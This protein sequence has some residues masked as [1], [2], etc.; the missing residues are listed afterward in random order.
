VAAD[1]KRW[2]AATLGALALL[3]PPSHAQTQRRS[4]I[5]F[6]SPALQALQRDDAQNPAQLWVKD[7]EALWAQAAPGGPACASCHPAASVPTMAARHPAWDERSARPITLAGRIDQCR[8]RHQ[9][10]TPQGPDGPEVLALA[11]YLAQAARGLP[12]A[13]ALDLQQ[14]PSLQR[15]LTLGERLWTQRMGQLNLA[16]A[17]CHDQ[18]AGGKLGGATI[19]QAHPTGYPSYRLEWQA[20][21]SLPR[22]LRGC[23]VGVRAEPFA[24]DADEWLALELHLARRAASMP[25]EGPAVRP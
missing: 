13:P 9:R 24:P 2:A 5:D 6:M 19:P 16:C 12:W 17:Q 18:H 14:H 4:G 10:A 11:A 23:L 15:W 3:A 1:L 22:R 21:G 20:L 7:G 8:Q 25:L